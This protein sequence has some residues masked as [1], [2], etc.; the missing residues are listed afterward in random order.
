M[1]K[2]RV[3]A[4]DKPEPFTFEERLHIALGKA[5]FWYFLE[6]IFIRSF[7]GQY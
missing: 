3:D 1:P 2:F 5:Y 6:H 4:Q 7:E